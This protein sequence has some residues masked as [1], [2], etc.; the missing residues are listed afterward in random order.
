MSGVATFAGVVDF[1]CTGIRWG[2]ERWLFVVAFVAGDRKDEATE[3][4]FLFSIEASEPDTG[5]TFDEDDNGGFSLFLLSLMRPTF[6]GVAEDEATT[7]LG[8][9]AI[10]AR[11]ENRESK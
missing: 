4:A 10:E 8:E 5:R 3:G 9:K 11:I 6:F 2:P 7:R 1:V